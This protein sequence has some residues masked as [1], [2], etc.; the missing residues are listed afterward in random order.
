MIDK[1]HNI[2][3]ESKKMWHLHAEL[4]LRKLT[5]DDWPWARS[6]EANT[7]SGHIE[8]MISSTSNLRVIYSNSRKWNKNQANTKVAQ[9]SGLSKTGLPVLWSSDGA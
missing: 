3:F 4:D 6:S 8:K 2:R 1:T 7:N 5:V 9:S